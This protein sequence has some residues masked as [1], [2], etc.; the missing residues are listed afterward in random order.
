MM[1]KKKYKRDKEQPHDHV[2]PSTAMQGDRLNRR[3]TDPLSN[4]VD[5][6]EDY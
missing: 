3:V 2:K 5:C 1:R 4:S 6:A